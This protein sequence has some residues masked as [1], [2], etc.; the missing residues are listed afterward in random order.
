MLEPLDPSTLPASCQPGAI[1][2]LFKVFSELRDH[3]LAR[4]KGATVRQFATRFNLLPQK[5]TQFATGS[6]DASPPPWYLIMQLCHELGFVVVVTPDGAQIYE[7]PKRKAAAPAD[8]AGE[9]TG[10]PQ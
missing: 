5:A 8:Q 6:G 10:A 3:W 9:G 7:D 4:H 2:N 1:P